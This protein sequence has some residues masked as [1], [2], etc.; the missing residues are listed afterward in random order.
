MGPYPTQEYFDSLKRKT[1]KLD[2]LAIL[3][4][5]RRINAT[6]VAGP[7]PW[8]ILAAT[9]LASL[10]LAIAMWLH[11]Y[12]NALFFLKTEVLVLAL[13]VSLW[14]KDLIIEAQYAGLYQVKTRRALRQGF[15]IFLVSE[16][17]FFFALF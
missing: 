6:F 5:R 16:V 10:F 1:K 11:Y 17:M 12:N 4:S 8:P 15:L 3:C 7:S 14:F 2:F 9:A 13:V